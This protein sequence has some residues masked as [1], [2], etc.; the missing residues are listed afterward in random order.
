MPFGSL[1]PA[2]L[3][4]IMAI[5]LIVFGPKKLPEI[6]RGIGNAL[7]E[8]N[9][10]RNDFMS[11]LNSEMETEEHRTESSTT[12]AYHPPLPERSLEYPEPPPVARTD[13]YPPDNVDALPYGGDFHVSEETAEP[14]FRTAEPE[15]ALASNETPGTG[16][17]EDDWRSPYDPAEAAP[18]AGEGRA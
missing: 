7:R 3:V 18:R 2:E 9:K 14:T 13:S 1:G 10:A 12:S 8:F 4:L 15:P 16:P 6:G 5:A 11:T 17:A